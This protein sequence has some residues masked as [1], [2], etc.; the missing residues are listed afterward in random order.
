MKYIKPELSIW[1][2][3]SQTAIALSNITAVTQ[4]EKYL[5]YNYGT[6]NIKNINM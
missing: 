3:S 6:V 5:K 2:Y 4:S 1:T